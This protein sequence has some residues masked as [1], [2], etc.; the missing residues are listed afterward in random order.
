MGILEAIVYLTAIIC[1]TFI[2]ISVLYKDQFK[3]DEKDAVE[4][5][6]TKKMGK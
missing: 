6:S 5:S 1:A 2:V 3:G 4:K